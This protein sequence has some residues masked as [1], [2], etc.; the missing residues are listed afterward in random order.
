MTYDRKR[1]ENGE[2]PTDHLF[3]P[4]SLRSVTCLI[5]AMGRTRCTGKS[6]SK[7]GVLA[8]E[9]VSPRRTRRR[10][11]RGISGL[12][13]RPQQSARPSEADGPQGRGVRCQ[14]CDGTIPY[15]ADLATVQPC[16][17]QIC[18]YCCIFSHVER[19]CMPHTCPIDGCNPSSLWRMASS[20]V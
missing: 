7:R 9:D 13:P 6:G 15:G 14:K 18:A 5:L 3:I 2:K 20:R 4:A 8:G 19:G 1:K 11:S 17:H 16:R 12:G 10:V